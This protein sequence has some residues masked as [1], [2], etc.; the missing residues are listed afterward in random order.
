MQSSRMV[1]GVLCLVV[2]LALGFG[3]A[4]AL[5]QTPTGC[6]ELVQNGGFETTAVWQLGAT[7]A[8]PQY[9]TSNPHSGAW[10]LR[11]GIADGVNRQTFSSVR[12]TVTIP[13][14]AQKATLSFWVNTLESGAPDA[15][16]VEAV[17]LSP[18]GATTLARLWYAVGR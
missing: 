2:M 8:P 9:V 4:P 14:S 1:P 15:D 16:Y 12:Q 6:T 11:M 10:S 13:A 7:A 3:P 17:L 18:D 5:A